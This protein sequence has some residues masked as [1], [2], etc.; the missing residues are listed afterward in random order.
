MTSQK[1]RKLRE[2]HNLTQE[3][4]ALMVGVNK[5]VVS[6][7]ERLDKISKVYSEKL[8]DTFDKKNVLKNIMKHFNVK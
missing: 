6:R 4:V 7:W 1:L 3:D 5:T 8:D 2:K